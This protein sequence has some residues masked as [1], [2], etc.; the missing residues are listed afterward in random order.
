MPNYDY[1]C[2][3]C[4]L[5]FERQQTMSEAAIT[6]CP[7]CGASVQRLVTGGAGFIMKGTSSGASIKSA[8]TCSLETTGRT[9]C[10]REQRCGKPDCGG[11]E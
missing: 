5:K 11:D 3:S 1:Y 7:N 9:C 4:G 8:K 10:G 6:Q 2:E